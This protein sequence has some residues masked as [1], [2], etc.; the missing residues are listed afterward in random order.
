[1]DPAYQVYFDKKDS[2]LIG[3]SLEKIYK[4]F[5]SIEPGSSIK[6]KKF[7]KNAENNYNIAIKDFVKDYNSYKGNAY[8]LANTLFQKAFLKPKLKI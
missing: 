6:L 4:A 8:G 1:M 2:V 3:D 5:Q 7:I